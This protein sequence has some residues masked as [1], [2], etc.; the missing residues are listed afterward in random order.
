MKLSKK[1]KGILK[2]A[3]IIT[4]SYFI[5]TTLY[6]GHGNI[7]TKTGITDFYWC[8]LDNYWKK[9]E[10]S[11]FLINE[12]YPT[13]LDGIDGPFVYGNKAFYVN[14]DSQLI[15]KKVASS[16]LIKVET[17]SKEFPGFS[18]Q[19]RDSYP[20]EEFTH[21]MP[22]KLIAISDIEG[23]LTGFYSF[24]LANKVIDSE[25]N[26]IF[27]KGALVLNGDFF[28]R[29]NQVTPLLWFIYHLENQALKVGGKVHFIL[30]N[31]E[32][33]NLN[34]DASHNDFKYIAV[35]KKISNETNWDKAI[36][37]LY[38]ENSELGKWLR[39]KNIIEKIGS[40]IFVHG[41]LNKFH[42]QQKITLEEMNT[43]ARKHFG[44]EIPLEKPNDQRIASIISPI[45]GPY[46]DR[47]L[48]LDWK[49]KWTYLFNGIDAE[50]TPQ[51]DLN[52]ILKFYNS[53]KIIIGHSM[54]DD[55]AA[56]YNNKVI[57]I[58]V[59]H[60]QNSKSGH[61]KGLLIQNNIYYKINDLG[62]KIALFE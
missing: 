12:P 35:A 54:V 39:S 8:G 33:M 6:F 17:D 60:G 46:W 21:E 5:I 2:W 9:N 3:F 28:D 50:E 61:T 13:F 62:D 53:E 23:N 36:L 58:D 43:I 40:H 22:K 1:G 59:K 26:W 44:K 11:G 55:I 16:R 47:R 19:L 52:N 18:V 41:G 48:N 10:P 30:G 24:L 57:K 56:G 45:N 31:H 7:D 51:S 14:R 38:G 25:G 49:V 29:G 37:H 20:T 27:G 42:L 4:T 34:G 32:V 15:E